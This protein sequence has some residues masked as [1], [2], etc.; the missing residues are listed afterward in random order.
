MIEPELRLREEPL[1]PAVLAAFGPAAA[2]L[3]ERLLRM[4]DEALAALSGVAGEGLLLV[5]GADLPWVD[6][7]VYLGR[8]PAAPA[9]FLPTTL[10]SAVPSALLERA[11]RNRNPREL[12]PLAVLPGDT[13]LRVVPL[14]VAR[15]ID[16][17]VL[18]ALRLAG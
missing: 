8:D 1:P 14:G 11:L 16:R 10:E 4:S 3:R 17:G 9:L 7:A 18:E 2:R 13:G 12:A 6:G 5:I 15:P